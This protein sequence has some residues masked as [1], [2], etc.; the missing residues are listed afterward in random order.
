MVLF[1]ETKINPDSWI[2]KRAFYRIFGNI[3]FAR[4]FSRVQA[5]TIKKGHELER[6]VTDLT[7]DL[8]IDDIDEFLA[9]QIHRM[10]VRIATKSVIKDSNKLHGHGIEPDF[11]IFERVEQSQNCYIVE[12]KDGHEHDTK[13]SAKEHQNLHMFLSKNAMAFES[14]RSYCKI[15]GFNAET[16][17]EIRKG[18]K[19]KIAPEQAMTGA[20]F[21]KLLSLDYNSIL[22]HRASF[23]EAN[24]NSVL[25][26]MLA[27]P[28]IKERILNQLNG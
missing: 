16:R 9:I 7:K 23:R 14:F 15:V 27:I 28:E 12:V 24:I 5:L 3:E 19:N 26:E 25:R 6:I 1:D 2:S 17:E 20:E 10:G 8:H 11:I 13:G 18:F 21:C 4:I 22:A